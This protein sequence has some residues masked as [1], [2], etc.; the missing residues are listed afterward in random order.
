M[1]KALDAAGA[2]ELLKAIKRFERADTEYRRAHHSCEQPRL[3]RAGTAY[4]IAKTAL[5]KAARSASS[6]PR[7]TPT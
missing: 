7:G 3:N 4:A 5:F 6:S 1:T 2:E